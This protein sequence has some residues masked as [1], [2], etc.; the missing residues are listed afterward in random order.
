MSAPISIQQSIDFA[1]KQAFFSSKCLAE[2]GPKHLNVTKRTEICLSDLLKFKN[3]VTTQ[4]VKANSCTVKVSLITNQHPMAGNLRPNA[5]L[6]P[7]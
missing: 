5:F 4:P 1:H 2:S 6:Q 3:T 7:E